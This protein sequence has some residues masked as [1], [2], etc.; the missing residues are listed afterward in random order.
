MR[1]TVRSPL[2]RARLCH[3][4]RLPLAPRREELPLGK[5]PWL[6]VSHGRSLLQAGRLGPAAHTLSV[7]QER[8]AARHRCRGIAI[9]GG[10][11]ASSTKMKW[12]AAAAVEFATEVARSHVPLPLRLCM[13]TC[14][15]REDQ[16]QQQPLR[17]CMPRMLRSL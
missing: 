1:R 7:S 11:R 14:P 16:E 10:S 5:F 6:I 12:A 17:L 15:L 9:C 13:P 4:S 3:R 8:S 2:A